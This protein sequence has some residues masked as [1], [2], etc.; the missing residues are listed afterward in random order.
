M[1]SQHHGEIL[2]AITRQVIARMDRLPEIKAADLFKRVY[3]T[4]PG[5][6]AD[7]DRS[8][9]RIEQFIAEVANQ[10]MNLAWAE[11]V[12]RYLTDIIKPDPD[13]PEQMD[14]FDR[15]FLKLM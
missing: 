14:L 8:K 4:L 6:M 2:G 11:R 9:C 7:F 5:R 13:D 12:T 15:C 1:W 10:E 3:E